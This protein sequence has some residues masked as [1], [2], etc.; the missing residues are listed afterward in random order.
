MLTSGVVRSLTFKANKYGPNISKQEA[1]MN[2][3]NWV[4]TEP[5]DDVD[6]LPVSNDW[7]AEAGPSSSSSVSGSTGPSPAATPAKRARK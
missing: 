6:D 3:E 7:P 5:A 1:I 4:I 2:S